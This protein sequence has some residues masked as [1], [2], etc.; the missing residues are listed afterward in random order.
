MEHF[1]IRARVIRQKPPIDELHIPI[2]VPAS[3]G[4][5]V[6]H[7]AGHLLLGAHALRG[8]EC[9][10]HH[11]PGMLPHLRDGDGHVCREPWCCEKC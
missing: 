11:A 7:R 8:H 2:A 4:S 1:L 5:E 10:R 6:Q 3:S 9:A